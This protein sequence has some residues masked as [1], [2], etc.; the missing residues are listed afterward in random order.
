M[1]TSLYDS[2]GRL[3]SQTWYNTSDVV[4][5][6]ESFTYDRDGNTLTAA[7]DNGTYTMTYDALNRLTSAQ[8]PFG[9]TLTYTYDADGNRIE[10]QDSLGGVT[11]YLYD[12]DN[13]LVSEQF[14]GAGQTPLRIDLTYDA[15]GEI[16]TETRYS[17]LAGTQVVGTTSYTYDGDG[18]VT[19]IV[20]KDGSGNTLADFTYTYN[21]GGLVTSET[22]LGVT[23]TFTYDADDE[24]LGETSSLTKTNYSYDADGNQSGPG[25]VIGPGNQ[26]L[27]DGT[28][29]YT[30]DADGNLIEK[31]GVSSGPD[32]G[33]TW[34]YTY[35][36]RN[37]MTSA[38]ETQG[39]NTLETVTYRYDVFGNRI[40]E[41]VNNGS[42]LQITRF[43]YDGTNIWADLDG[44]NNLVTRRLYICPME[45]PVARISNSGTAAWYL[46]DNLG[47]VRV[48]TDNTGAVIDEINYDA[49]GNILNQT[50]PFGQRPL[51]LDRP[52]V[53]FSHGLTVQPCAVLRPDD[54]PLDQPRPDRVCRG[55]HE[56][57]PLCGR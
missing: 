54:R 14:G 35:E 31:V 47:S 3:L 49:Y 11:T 5:N 26:L 30:Y 21:L 9:T 17:N 32:A 10:T 7:D 44:F 13:E 56:P 37:Q 53:R 4:V 20:D 6:T 23:T 38:V 12:A 25:I 41:D 57:L 24:V 43:A 39:S 1:T 19:S 42:G 29:N 28:W 50:E 16:L 33:L 22:G 40:E 15:D 2:D 8:E 46:T 51:P 52:A 45:A 55:R 48:L 36:N 34:T 27:S 18:E